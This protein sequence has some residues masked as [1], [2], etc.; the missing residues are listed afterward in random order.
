MITVKD[1]LDITN[2]IAPFDLAENWDNSGLQVGNCDW[3]VK[4][5]MVSLEATQEVI[6]AAS[7]W[8]ADVILTHHPLIISPMKSISFEKMPGKVIHT[9]ATNKISIITAHTNLDKADMGLNDYFANLLGIK[10]VRP[11]N[12][13]SRDIEHHT[14]VMG[15]GRI[16]RFEAPL[17]L[18][19]LVNTIKQK[20]KIK[21]LR[22]TGNLD[23][24]VESVAI[25][26]GSGGSLL[27]DFLDS[28]AQIYITGDSKYHEARLVEEYGRILIDVGHFASEHIVVDLLVERLAKESVKADLPIKI[29]GFKKEKDPFTIM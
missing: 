1:I 26:T 13:D 14:P 24:M 12:I 20:L 28:D 11:L 7:N 6:T 3:E 18:K 22:V 2:I 23:T 17:L 27:K 9:C 21:N 25:C 15:I 4:K 8:D 5:V 19:N 16:G 29:Q 10:I